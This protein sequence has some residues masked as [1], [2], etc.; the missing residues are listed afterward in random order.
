MFK[1]LKQQ[2]S[3][4]RDYSKYS[5][6][7]REWLLT[8]IEGLVLVGVCGYFFYRSLIMTILL[9]P[10]VFTYI[11]R[12]Q[13]SLCE[14]RKQQLKIQFKEVM[15]SV[16]SSVT[17]GYSLEN[18][19][20]EAYLDIAGLFGENSMMAQELLLFK[21]GIRN[22]QTI[23]ELL[24]DFG[25]RS[26]IEDIRNFAEV[27]VI[28]KR[29]GGRIQEIIQNSVEVIEEKM[30]VTQE[31]ETMVS[32]KRMEL[33]VMNVIP[34]FIIFY[35]E[36]TSPRFFHILYHNIA[37]ICIMSICLMIYLGAVVLAEK[38]VHITV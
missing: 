35:V 23:E 8:I 33:R 10:L 13:N 11:K 25:K 17:A 14:K 26:D 27:L 32:A 24:S 12:K 34:F 36:L 28:G 21:R 3:G 5:L 18:A 2:E 4:Y 19:F 6:S 16:L 7:G 37:G 9:M 30:S 20:F 29:S 1:S 15:N 38:M 22:N 31:I